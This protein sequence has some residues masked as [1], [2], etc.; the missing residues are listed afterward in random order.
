MTPFPYPG[1]K[2]HIWGLHFSPLILLKTSLNQVTHLSVGLTDCNTTIPSMERLVCS[3][4]K[5][6]SYGTTHLHISRD[7]N[8]SM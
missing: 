2:W 6:G 4:K 5:N 3:L 8:W 1:P 7:K